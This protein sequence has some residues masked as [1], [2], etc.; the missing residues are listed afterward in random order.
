MVLR[1]RGLLGL[2]FRRQCVIS[3]FIVD[4]YCVER[5]VAIEIDGPAHQE[6]AR[7]E[8]DVARTK[9]LQAHG[10]RVVRI[11]NE[12]VSRR[13][14]ERVLRDLL[15]DHAPSPRSGEGVRG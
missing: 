11:R 13:G 7:A 2:K 8:Y 4:F 3:G 12:D 1:N 5:N 14:L 10:V 6:T 9:L 15:L